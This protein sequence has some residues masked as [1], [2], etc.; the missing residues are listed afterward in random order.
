MI[1]RVVR[2]LVWLV[3]APLGMFLVLWITGELWESVVGQGVLV[4]LVMV[5]LAGTFMLIKKE[6]TDRE[7]KRRSR[8]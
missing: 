2:L 5:W 3:A 8:K 6:R 4:G 1:R 7:D